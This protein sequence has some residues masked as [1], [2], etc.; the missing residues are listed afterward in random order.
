[1]LFRLAET[2]EAQDRAAAASSFARVLLSAGRVDQARP[3]ALDGNDPVLVAR[4][5]LEAHD[6]GEA[7]RLLDEARLRDPF[8]PRIASARGRLGFLE[9]RFAEAVR[10]LLE[11]AL[12]R[13]DGLPDSGDRRFLRAA[14]AL[15]P[16]EIPSWPDAVAAA[17]DRLAA[18][19]EK[20]ASGV[21]WPDR[22]ADLLRS[23]IRRRGAAS[24]G[25]LDRARRLAELPAL[26]GLDESAL[27]AAAAAGELRRLA[28]GSPLYRSG[29]SSGEISFVVQGALD[30]VRPTPVGDQ[31]MGEAQPGDL[32]GEEAF[33]GA[34]RTCDAR[35]RGAVTLLGFTVDFFS[36]DPDRAV[37]LRYLRARL[38]R[39]LARLNDLFRKFFPDEAKAPPAGRIDDASEGEDKLSLED[40]SRSLTTV[41][42][43]ESDRFLFAVFADERSYP[44]GAVIFREGDAGDAIYVIARGRVRISRRISGGE[45]AFAVLSAGEI[46]GEMAIL[47]PGSGR[48]ADA[49]VHE[50]AVVLELPRARFD[51]LEAADPEG[52]VELS[53]LLCRLAARRAVET[54]ERL[55]NWRVLAGPG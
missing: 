48:S 33:V 16:A 36:S 5:L 20:R 40:R 39:R 52:C 42:L 18:E 25:V 31:P 6:F 30:L 22:S 1:M 21:A 19:A 29:E 35:A 11:A 49:V 3:F 44:E 37:W 15:A 53:A 51:A 45:E 24:E 17:R 10:D 32:V 41:G 43:S 38:A 28:T 13:P 50:D 8:D 14:R 12:L 2:L 23:L 34:P 55:A 4:L 27:F 9:K 7:R 54:A 26:Q 46:F 47:D